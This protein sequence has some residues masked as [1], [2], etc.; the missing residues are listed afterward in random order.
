MKPSDVSKRFRTSR[1]ENRFIE[2]IPERVI[3][4]SRGRGIH[5]HGNKG[6][7]G[8]HTVRAFRSS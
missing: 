8:S 4:S 2:E 7:T 5:L 6:F 3:P 1:R